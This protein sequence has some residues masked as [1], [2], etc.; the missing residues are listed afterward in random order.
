MYILVSLFCESDK[1]N[2]ELNN[3]VR[4]D[5]YSTDW[6]ITVLDVTYWLVNQPDLLK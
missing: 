1:W 5:K 2:M 4:F 3:Y 6:F